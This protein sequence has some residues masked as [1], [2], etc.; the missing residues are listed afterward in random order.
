VDASS[1]VYVADT[2]N[3]RVEKFS[4]VGTLLSVWHFPPADKRSLDRPDGIAVDAQGYV[5][6]SDRGHRRVELWSPNGQVAG[7][8]GEYYAPGQLALD[9]GGRAY[10]A[11]GMHVFTDDFANHTS[12]TAVNPGAL[13]S[14]VSPVGVAAD[15]RG[16]IYVADRSGPRI[17][18]F[19]APKRYFRE[20]SAGKTSRA[21]L[22]DIAGIAVGRGG[23]VYVADPRGRRIARFSPS[24]KLLGR[25]GPRLSPSV[26]DPEGVALDSSEDVYITDAVTNRVL[27]LSAAGQFIALRGGIG[28]RPGK[29]R[30]PLGITIDR[31][32]NIYV[33]DS[34]NN[35]IERLG[36]VGRVTGVLGG[37]RP[38]GVL[39]DAAGQLSSP[40][41]MA[42]DEGGRIYVADTFNKRVQVFDKRGAWIAAWSHFGPLPGLQSSLPA[43]IAI[44]P[45]HE[46]YVAD[47]WLGRLSVL[48]TRGNLLRYWSIGRAKGLGTGLAVTGDGHVFLA[49]ASTGRV[50]IYASTGTLLGFLSDHNGHP[51]H[52]ADPTAV[53]VYRDRIVYVADAGRH[54]VLKFV[55]TRSRAPRFPV[56]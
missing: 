54:R 25:W 11:N 2:G 40:T 38:R 21:G 9:A 22:K 29:F 24:G 10:L 35:R 55:L 37:K 56:S 16:N 44:G 12:S 19:A 26:G 1:Y 49:D 31:A 42:V 48:T 15:T 27:E 53:A 41:D 17:E 52:F 20:W 3:D 4:P 45:H 36:P 33:A 7:S 34:S 23:D 5:Y 46:V 47:P 6:V 50:A 28:S 18:K 39:P 51:L 13:P 14:T 30:Q 32:G 43:A 8:Y